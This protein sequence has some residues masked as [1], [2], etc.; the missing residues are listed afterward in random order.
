MGTDT[1]FEAMASPV[2]RDILSYLA[3]NG[4]SSAGD[5]AEHIDQVARTSVSTH[6]RLLR[7][8]G[9]ITERRDGRRRLYRLDREGPATAALSYFQS[10]MADS[11]RHIPE[12]VSTPAFPADPATTHTG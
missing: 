6:L 11:L 7:T 5:I 8:C 1:V 10:L 3:Q 9:L 2:R 12:S 4:E